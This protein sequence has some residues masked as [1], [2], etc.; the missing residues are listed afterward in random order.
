MTVQLKEIS[1]SYGEKQVLENITVNIQDNLLTVLIGPSGS[2]KTT[3]LSIIA[4]EITPQTGTATINGMPVSPHRTVW[5]PQGANS[6]PA[7][8]LLDNVLIAPLASGTERAKARQIAF[9]A[10]ESVG[11]KQRH[12]S[13]ARELSGGELQRLAIARALAS[14]KEVLLAD[15]PTANLDTKNANEIIALLKNIRYEKTLLVATHD[16]AVLQAADIILDMHKINHQT[17]SQENILNNTLNICTQG[18]TGKH[19]KH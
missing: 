7:R 14:Q 17:N 15:E 12:N 9:T 10:L 11:L 3:L 8:T 5:I 16:P 13:L 4:G 6:L 2:G 18:E 19:A 1:H